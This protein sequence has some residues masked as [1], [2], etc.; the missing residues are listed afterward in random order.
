MQSPL[1]MTLLGRE[2]TDIPSGGQT[3]ATRSTLTCIGSGI[4]PALSGK[5]TDGTRR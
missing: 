1:L 3:H 2:N 4:V 5:P